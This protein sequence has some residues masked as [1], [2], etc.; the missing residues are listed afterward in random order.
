MAT[1]PQHKPQAHAS[2][3]WGK[4]HAVLP[5]RFRSLSM[6]HA[7][8]GR[9]G[10]GTRSFALRY[11]QMGHGT[12]SFLPEPREGPSH[13]PAVLMLHAVFGASE[14]A[15]IG[16]HLRVAW[17]ETACTVPQLRVAWAETACIGDHLR[18]A[19]AETACN[20]R[21]LRE[22]CAEGLHR[23]QRPLHPFPCLPRR[24]PTQQSHVRR[25][26]LLNNR[27]GTEWLVREVG[28]G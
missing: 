20:A 7:V 16:D 21:Q 22:P 26:Q 27:V 6:V 15:C 25:T 2:R 23:A 13:L 3:S 4:E 12:R 19:W 1:G 5:T 9:L 14:T 18:V 24:Q 8:L 10:H 11:T 17:A 28:R